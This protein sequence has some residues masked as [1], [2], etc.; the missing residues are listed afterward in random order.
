MRRFKAFNKTTIVVLVFVMFIFL[1]AG[2]GNI[3]SSSP[4]NIARKIIRKAPTKDELRK[5][6]EARIQPLVN[7]ATITKD[8]ANKVL[9]YLTANLDALTKESIQK[10]NNTL[11]KLVTDKVITQQ[12]ADKIINALRK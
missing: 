7:D 6:Y 1:F 9:N 3:T 10:Q 5:D 11:N 8:Q 12:Q 4:Q 2:C